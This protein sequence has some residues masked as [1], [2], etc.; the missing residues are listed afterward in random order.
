ALSK[1]PGAWRRFDDAWVLMD[2]ADLA[3][4]NAEH[5]YRWLREHRPQVNAWF[6]LREDSPD[7]ARLRDEGFRMMPYGSVAHEALLYHA[8]EYLSSHAGVDVLRPM[9]DR[10]VTLR[11]KWR[12][13]FLQHGVIHNDL[14]IWLNN[15]RFDLFVASTHDEYRGIVGD[16]SPYLFTDREVK[17][18]G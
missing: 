8:T 1:V 9:G 7:F 5:L 15:Q 13:T 16:G 3:G 4:D 11:P 10:L 18:V 12:F 14:S 6:V 17:L 2:R